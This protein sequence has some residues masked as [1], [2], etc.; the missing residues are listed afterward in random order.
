M[1]MRAFVAKITA[2]VWDIVQLSMLIT[3]Q[4]FLKGIDMKII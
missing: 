4:L 2:N 3:L 1:L